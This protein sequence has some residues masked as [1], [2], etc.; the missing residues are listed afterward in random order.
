MSDTHSISKGIVR[1]GETSALAVDPRIEYAHFVNFRP[2]DGQVCE[3]NPPRFSW[4]YDPSVISKEDHPRETLFTLQLSKTGDFSS[5]DLQ[6]KNTPYNF[7]NALP[8]LDQTLTWHWRVG[9]SVA[10]EITWNAARAFSFGPGTPEWDRT[11]I[12]KIGDHLKEHP[13]VPFT[14][15]QWEEI[16]NLHK[17][18]S[19]AAE[20]R[21]YAIDQANKVLHRDWWEEFPENDLERWKG[22]TTR[23]EGS[24]FYAGIGK[25]LETVAFAYKLTGDETFAGVKQRVLKMAAWPPGGFSSPEGMGA[26]DAKNSTWITGNLSLY[27]DWFYQD[28]S[29][30]EKRIILNSI[31]W[32]LEHNVRHYSWKLDGEVNPRGIGMFTTSHAYEDFLWTLPAALATYEHLPE[33]REAI[34]IGLHYLTGVTNPFGPEEAWNEGMAYGGWK[35]ATLLDTAL[36]FNFTVPDLHLERNPYWKKI[37]D[38]FTWLSPLGVTSCSFGNQGNSLHYIQGHN[39]NF[40]KLA[41][42]TGDGCMYRNWEQCHTW[43]GRNRGFPT[44]S[45]DYAICNCWNDIPQ[46]AVEPDT[47]RIFPVAGW[48]MADAKP[49]SDAA[50]YQNAVGMVY[51]C[52]PRGGY[53]HSFFSENAFDIFAYGDLIANGGGGTENRDPFARSTVSHNSILVDGVGQY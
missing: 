21:D 16:G 7:Y 11:V 46:P 44:P 34:E 52:R 19:V 28:L 50:E 24:K 18:N 29:D 12:S 48:A 45:I 30:E 43:E 37:G 42:L 51:H 23:F 15:D 31:Q 20:V 25:G 53:S 3:V 38:F 14:E 6:I 17:R 32:R 8:V 33:S 41:F 49:P 1:F 39:A 47:H 2:G 35:L 27:F 36:Y 9:Y 26:S 10:G 13:R 4:G 22:G 40:R 5:P